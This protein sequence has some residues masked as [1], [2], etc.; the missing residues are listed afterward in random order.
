MNTTDNLQPDTNAVS[1]PGSLSDA[2]ES[3][4]I[5]VIEEQLQVEK[6]V[7]ET[8]RLLVNKTVREEE[9]VVTT[10]LMHDEIS[11]ERV[12]INKYV[13]TIPVVRYEDELTIIPV[14][15]EVL[16]LEK[17][18]MLVEEV[19][20]TK[21]RLSTDDTQRVMLRREEVTV[22]RVSPNETDVRSE[23]GPSL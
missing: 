9:Q 3:R 16:V 13:E 8:G 15:K 10:P 5:P 12:P 2:V 11:V 4:V 6:Q 20:I 17:R 22:E 21:R 18:L 7:I 19:H 14:V 23:T 1:T